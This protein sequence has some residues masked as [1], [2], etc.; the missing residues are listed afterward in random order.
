MLVME[1]TGDEKDGMESDVTVRGQP[2]TT[3][4]CTLGGT[5]Q[6]L[7]LSSRDLF[8]EFSQNRVSKNNNVLGLQ[9]TAPLFCLKWT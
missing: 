9:L 5:A 4:V 6:P 3:A 2:R 1:I 8:C 7:S